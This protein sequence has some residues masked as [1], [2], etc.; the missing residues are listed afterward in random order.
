MSENTTLSPQQI[1]LQEKILAVE[2]ICVSQGNILVTGR[3][4]AL[5]SGL[6]KP[7]P[8]TIL[9]MND[10]DLWTVM[11]QVKIRKVSEDD[12]MFKEEQTTF[13][14]EKYR[15]AISGNVNIRFG[16]GAPIPI[17]FENEQNYDDPDNKVIELWATTQL[18]TDCE[19]MFGLIEKLY[20]FPQYDIH[21]SKDED[22]EFHLD[23]VVPVK[24]EQ[25]V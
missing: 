6:E 18:R 5:D 24:D 20:T 25:N 22:G 9:I 7:R 16:E 12:E 8:F 10:D 19:I 1:E 4:M 15:E 23:I 2:N 3:Q 11:W 17:S 13:V 14:M 21:L